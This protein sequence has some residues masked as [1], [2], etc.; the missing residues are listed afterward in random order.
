MRITKEDIE[1]LGFKV[2][3][4]KDNYREVILELP[5]ETKIKLLNKFN[6]FSPKKP[7]QKLYDLHSGQCCYWRECEIVVDFTDGSLFIV[8]PFY[9]HGGGT[10][11]DLW[12]VTEDY[13]PNIPLEEQ[14]KKVINHAQFEDPNETP[15]HALPNQI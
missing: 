13:D 7:D 4:I 12:P 9:A 5:E 15:S 3:K 1:K 2:K 14:Y 8:S 11:I 6:I 10:L